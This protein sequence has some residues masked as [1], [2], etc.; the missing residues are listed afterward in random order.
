MFERNRP[1]TFHFDSKKTK[2][3]CVTIFCDT[4]NRN[5]AQ[6]NLELCFCVV[7]LAV[8]LPL[9]SGEHHI[10]SYHIKSTQKVYFYLNTTFSRNGGIC[11]SVLRA[12]ASR[13]PRT[14]S[15]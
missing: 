13:L 10:I 14:M 4:L 6:F 8:F 7:F 11:L 5:M 1:L 15:T 9:A 3:S 2:T 12:G